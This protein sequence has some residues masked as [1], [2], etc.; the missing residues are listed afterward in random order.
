MTGCARRSP[1]RRYPTSL[2]S[3]GRFPAGPESMRLA[4]RDGE[5]MAQAPFIDGG[6]AGM[7]AIDSATPGADA[8]IRAILDH[9]KPVAASQP[10][11]SIADT[12]ATLASEADAAQERLDRA[13]S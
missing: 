2:S 11:E 12:L 8:A 10:T 6:T 3:T 4:M 9:T 1:M 5:C 13:M 7:P